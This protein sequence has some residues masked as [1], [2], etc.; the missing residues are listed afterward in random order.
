M[1]EHRRKQP[2]GRGRRGAPQ[3]G[4]RA[5]PPP[6]P[7]A[8][9]EPPV[10][11]TAELTPT[12]P[13]YG[14]RAEARRAAQRS[15]GTS[16]RRRGPET[17]RKKRFIDYP[18]HNHTGWRRWVPSWKQVLGSALGF[19]VLLMGAVALA[20]YL[21]PLP[22]ANALATAQSNVYY[23]ADGSRMVVSGGDNVNR[24]IVPLD[25]ISVHMQDSVVA[26]E[27]QSFWTDSGID[28]RGIGRAMLNMA[29][30]GDVQSG[31]TITQQYVK[32]Y[33]LSQ[34]QTLTRKAREL[35]LSV[36]VGTQE[37]KNDIL[38]G[39]L[40]TACYN[41]GACGIQAAAQAYF[42]VDAR[43]LDASQSAF[44][45][46]LLKGPSL[47]DPYDSETGEINEANVA[48]A[49]ERWESTLRQRNEIEIRG[50]R[51]SD[52][53]LAAIL[54]EGFP[55]DDILPPTRAMVKAGQIGYLTELA[56]H[57]LIS[58]GIATEDELNGGGY[59]IWTTFDE[60]MVEQMQQAVQ[61]VSRE[62]L[63]P[64]AR[65]EDRH[66]QFGGAAVVPGD[67][68]I[69]A[70]YGGVDWTEHFRNNA[71]NP[72]VQ[73]G[74]T[75]K[76]F[77]LAAA[78]QYGVRDPEGPPDQ[79][80]SDRTIVS[81]DSVYRSENMLPIN[82]YDGEPAVVENEET[83]EEEQWRQANFEGNDQGDIT[84]REATV[85]SANSPFAQLGMDVGPERV[86]EAAQA[87]GLL[88]ESLVEANDSVPTFALGVST[89]GPIR[90]AS[91]YSTFAASGEQHEPYSVVEVRDDQGNRIFTHEE[92]STQAFD[93]AFAPDVANT[94]TDLLVDVIE[95]PDGSGHRAADIGFPVAGKT[96]TT[97]DNRSAWF[98]GYSSEL[99]TAI[100]MWRAPDD[101]EDLS[102]EEIEEGYG[103]GSFMPMYGT[104]DLE[105]IN[106]GSLPLSVWMEFMS[107][108][109]TGDEEEF[110]EPPEDFGDEVCGGGAD[111]PEDQPTQEPTPDPEPTTQ[112]PTDEPTTQ[113]PTPDPEPTTQEPTDEPTQPCNPFD[114]TC[115]TDSGGT[116]DG[117][118]DT[119]GTADGGTADG[120]TDTGGTDDGGQSNGTNGDTGGIFGGG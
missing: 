83:G 72:N 35:L 5:G 117:G 38:E 8:E 116:A 39:Y 113:E 17:P 42:G 21:I 118:A 14:T 87:A 19:C 33:F 2:P 16:R 61:Q 104:A 79:P 7:P 23:W 71:D 48:R 6:P 57:Y 98:V 114:P 120:G 77:V 9:T 25:E 65:D 91:A 4:R 90:M 92:E 49:A 82:R 43:D 60:T 20:Y 45:T 11:A 66:V 67:G 75:F 115:N 46:S 105:R 40:N 111:C 89:P 112:E 36:K 88:P 64:E 50:N 22:N 101:E 18:R 29:Q 52:E 100:G 94:V 86:S 51:L 110:P 1:S 26:A 84:L 30:G 27:N 76:P 3:N 109:A 24:Q 12:R 74:S 53:D 41:R 103:V 78:F 107:A 70:V 68:A 37:S 81:P 56:D 69:R 108:A 97:D 47:Y 119:G 93:Q 44:L 58:Q 80:D 59:Q 54:E 99:S 85:V 13:A 32:N 73:V 28:L 63:A 34:D 96:G 10:D 62:N 31:S 55:I 106:G 102:E 15:A 95:N